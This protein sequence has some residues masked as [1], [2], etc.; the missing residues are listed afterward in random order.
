MIIHINKWGR[1]YYYKF[2]THP[3]VKHNTYGCSH[4]NLL[5]SKSYCINGKL[6]NSFGPAIIYD[7]GVIEYWL[8]EKYFIYKEWLF[9][10]N[11]VEVD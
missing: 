8:N 4:Q 9:N 11:K 5:K 6:H 10:K 3:Y 7:D 2:L 1:K